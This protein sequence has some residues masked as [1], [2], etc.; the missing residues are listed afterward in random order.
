MYALLPSGLCFWCHRFQ[1]VF[2]TISASVISDSPHTI[3]V[4][5][6]TRIVDL[7]GK[8]IKL[9]VRVCRPQRALENCR[10]FTL[11]FPP[12]PLL[13][14][15]SNPTISVNRLFGQEISRASV[16]KELMQTRKATNELVLL[17]SLASGLQLRFRT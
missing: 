15:A 2:L 5:F 14:N 4:E 8:K 10:N 11:T 3:G 1:L 6:G 16:R 7:N 17:L 9:Q 13:L 12:H